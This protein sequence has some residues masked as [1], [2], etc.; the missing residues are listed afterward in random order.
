MIAVAKPCR[1]RKRSPTW[2]PAFLALLPRVR[3]YAHFAFRHLAPEAKQEAVQSAVTSALAAYVR[4]VQLGKADIAYA[5]PLALY[6]IRQHRG[7]RRLGSSLNIRDVSSPYAQKMKGFALQRLD[8]FDPDEQCSK[9]VLIEDKT[10]SPAELAASRID[11]RAW[12]A[13]LN[14]RDRQIAEY[15][16]RANRTG[17]TARKFGVSEGRVSQLRGELRDSWRRFQHEL[18]AGSAPSASA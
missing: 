9:E 7:G 8:K 13:T 12:M 3:R 18:P 16:A 6:A 10:V 17:E 11:V 5:A 4:L 14:R 15:L 2:H 1:A